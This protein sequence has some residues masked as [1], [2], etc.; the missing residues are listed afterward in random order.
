VLDQPYL[1]AFLN[2]LFL[3]RVA[4]GAGSLNLAL[5]RRGEDISVEV[6]GRSGRL[7]L[8]LS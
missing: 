4:L 3:H 7:G 6:T 5:L 1:P 8:Q 2:D